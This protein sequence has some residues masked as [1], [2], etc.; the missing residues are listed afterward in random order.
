MGPD[1]LG[2]HSPA[3]CRSHATARRAH[4]PRTPAEHRPAVLEQ[5]NADA[6]AVYG[7]HV[8]I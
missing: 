5:I 4:N 3:S 6:E 1:Q 2:D 8:N 7:F